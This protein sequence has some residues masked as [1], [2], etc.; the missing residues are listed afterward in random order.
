VIYLATIAHLLDCGPDGRRGEPWIQTN[1]C[2]EERWVSL[3]PTNAVHRG[4]DSQ[5]VALNVGVP[6]RD[7]VDRSAEWAPSRIQELESF[8]D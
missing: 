1:V 7:H 4:V 2:V 3:E 8:D 5:V 6:G